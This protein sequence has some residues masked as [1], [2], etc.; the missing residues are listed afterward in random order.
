MTEKTKNFLKAAFFF[1]LALVCIS[2]IAVKD[3]KDLDFTL[4]LCLGFGI[5]FGIAYLKKA[6]D[7]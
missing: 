6:F 3:A 5:F 4:Y 2:F 1:V 7:R